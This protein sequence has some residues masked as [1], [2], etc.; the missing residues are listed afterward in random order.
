MNITNEQLET[1]FK[2][3]PEGTD[4]EMLQEIFI[5][6]GHTIE[7]VDTEQAKQYI[8]QKEAGVSGSFAQQEETKVQQNEVKESDG[9]VKAI[10]KD[11]AGTLVVKPVVRAT[12]AATELIAPNSQAAEGFRQMQDAGEATTVAGIDVPAIKNFGEGGGKQIAGETLKS[13]SYLFPYGKVAGAVGGAV[14]SN[15][16]GGV[17]SGATGGYLADVGSKLEGGDKTI[18]QSLTPGL[19]TAIGGAIPVAG[20]IV[21]GTGRAI[22]KLGSK[23]VEAVIP[24]G[25]I[26]AKIL[27]T[28]QANNPFLKR[29]GDVLMGTEK[30]PQTAGKTVVEKGLFGT[31]SMVGV[32]SKR[33]TSNLWDNLISPRLKDSDQA[34]DLDAFFAKKEADII[35]KNPELSRQKALLE[36]L[37]AIKEDYAGTKVITVEQLQKFKEGWAQF[38]PDKAYK[39]KPITGAFNDVRNELANEARDTIYNLL[40]EDVRKAYL[41]YGNLLGLQEYGQ[42]AM[43]GAKLKAGSGTLISELL[44]QAVTPVGTIGGQI[45]YKLG[46]GIQLIGEAN[47]QN[48]AQVLGVPLPKKFPGDA[49]IDDISKTVKSLTSQR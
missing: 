36:A 15:I 9:I 47:A 14:G 19:G 23:A 46:K 2:N 48:V 33:A 1:I 3:A 38:V 28:Y 7:G 45:V 17:A 21:R 6:Q 13:A 12:Q 32:Q 43:T 37:D 22:S 18:G 16:V 11:I 25:A 27:Q 35:S 30:A 49:A 39:G 29:I 41:D 44:S 31:K 20:P 10:A 5:K 4:R 8:A 42:T 26:E 40:G 24:T 34:V